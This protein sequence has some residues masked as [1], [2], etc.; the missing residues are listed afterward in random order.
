MWDVQPLEQGQVDTNRIMQRSSTAHHGRQHAHAS[1]GGGGG[2]RVHRKQLVCF[3]AAREN[4]TKHNRVVDI[5]TR[6]L[7]WADESK[8]GIEVQSREHTSEREKMQRGTPPQHPRTARMRE[9][10]RDNTQAGGC[11]RPWL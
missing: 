6:N 3:E 9:Q 10:E 11:K 8:G 7:G 5:L 2:G 4:R 1:G